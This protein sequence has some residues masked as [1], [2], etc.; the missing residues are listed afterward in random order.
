MLIRI[1]IFINLNV[2]MNLKFN[3]VCER[4]IVISL[5]IHYYVSQL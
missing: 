5:S 2:L 3:L 1:N 4:L